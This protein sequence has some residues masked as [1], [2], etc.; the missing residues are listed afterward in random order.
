MWRTGSCQG[1]LAGQPIN[2]VRYY[3]Q[4]QIPDQDIEIKEE[5]N[6]VQP[7]Q[8][9]AL[10]A[11]RVPFHD[12]LKMCCSTI[13]VLDLFSQYTCNSRRVSNSLTSLWGIIKTKN[14]DQQRFELRLM[15]E[16]AGFEELLHKAILEAGRMKS[17][18]L[19]YSLLAL[20]KLGVSS[21]T[22]VVQTLLRVS[23][24]RLN[25]FDERSLS[26]LASSLESMKSGANVDA[27]KEG[28]R[29][30]IES[31]LPSFQSVVALQ[32]LMRHIGKDAPPHFLRKVEMKA[33]SMTDQFSL[34]NAQYMV[35]TLAAM[36]FCSKTL[37]D[38][39]CKKIAEDVHAVPF[40]RLLTVLRS[41]RELRYRDRALFTAVAQ[42]VASTIDMWDNKQVI[43]FLSVFDE[44]RFCPT[45]LM[46]A[47]LE[48]VVKDPNALT[49]MNVLS[50]LKTFSSLNYDMKDHR[51]PFLEGVTHVLQSSLPTI[52]ASKLLRA[53]S[54]LC[55][56]GHFPQ[57]P[58]EQ[59]L[60]A[61]TLEELWVKG[62]R[63]PVERKLQIVDL[64]LRLDQPALPQGLAVP[65]SALASTPPLEQTVNSELA[66]TLHG[67]VGDRGILQEGV[68]VEKLYFIDCVIMRPLRVTEKTALSTGESAASDERRQ[69]IAVMWTPLS[70][71]CY[72]TS[73]PVGQVAMKLR[74]LKIL[75]YTPVLVME[76][77]LATLPEEE[78][79][80]ALRAQIFLEHQEL[81]TL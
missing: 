66:K 43:V 18:D 19:A 7:L 30:I 21:N 25:E 58:L 39:C 79:A 2:I 42:H 49:L 51:Q 80:E 16:H 1:H 34:P 52:S 64:C 32:T 38:V 23:Q 78:R 13:D 62:G 59:L 41:C 74:H 3:S 11:K 68:V 81:S 28:V 60:Q 14:E 53:V 4:G 35:S 15:F 33:L 36:G 65:P 77:E 54:C 67:L 72:G 26:V 47:F 24:E 48:R 37:L 8:S 70:S 61:H 73:H 45:P 76:N 69:R 71:V 10:Q 9:A 5:Q 40:S 29:L 17:I 12:K 31:R 55:V 22:R 75:G 50:V 56:L 46:D 44:L 27:L 63:V 6:S 20:V 57:A